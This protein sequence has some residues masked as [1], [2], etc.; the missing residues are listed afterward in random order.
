MERNKRILVVDDQ[1][2][3]CDQLSKL[4]LRSGKK[5]ETLSLV[6]QMRAKLMGSAEDL[7]EEAFRPMAIYAPPRDQLPK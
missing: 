2:D 7:E 3:L 6:Q 5:N 1:Q 4:L